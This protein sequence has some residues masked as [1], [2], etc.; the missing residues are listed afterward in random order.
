MPNNHKVPSP[1]SQL[2]FFLAI[3]GGALILFVFLASAI[4]H[5]TGLGDEIRSGAAWS[6]PRAINVM[7]WVQALFSLMV[8]GL[9][10]YFYA[11][12]TFAARPLYQLGLRPAVRVN[13]YLLG[14]LLL[15]ISLPLEGWL[16]DLNKRIPLPEWMNQ[17]EKDNGRQV[18]IFL[19]RNTPF[20]PVINLL[21]MAVIPA[22]CEELCFRGALQRIMIRLFKNPWTGI[23]V[24]AFLFSF[25]HFEF[26]GFLPRMFL[27]ILLGAACWYSGSL[28]V[29]ILGHL[30]FNG[31]QVAAAMFDPAMVSKNP[32]IPLYTVLLSMVIIVGLLYR[33]QKQSTV[34]Y[35]GVFGLP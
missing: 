12:Q 1:W 21:I 32:S 25:F 2:S 13:F 10:G 26:Q 19:K 16:G 6:D 33:M 27:G 3:A 9:P 17:L 18:E 31:I 14:V 11:R 30:F 29:P 24:A 20:D 23:I 35:A 34:S 5:T 7:K 15:L 4:Y 8:F 28:W 22:F